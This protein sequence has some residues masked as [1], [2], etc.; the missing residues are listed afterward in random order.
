[1]RETRGQSDPAAE[2]NTGARTTPSERDAMLA[3][4]YDDLRQAAA[5]LLRRDAPHLTLQPTELVNE[6]ALRLMRLD[7]MSFADRQHFF[8]TSARVL[9]QAMIDAIRTRRA[10]KRQSPGLMLPEGADAGPALDIEAL[11][12]A[13]VRLETAA[14]D[15]ARLVELRFFAGLT[16]PEI[17]VLCEESESTVKRRWKTARL[18]LAAELGG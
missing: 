16:V 5:R 8:A 4:V 7:R 10:S 14:P 11:D 18:W 15:L 2:K 12:A 3:A 6:A 9:R 17:A 1:V 13:L